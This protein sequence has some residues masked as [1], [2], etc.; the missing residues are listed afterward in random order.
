MHKF[1]SFSQLECSKFLLIKIGLCIIL[2]LTMN[3]V[4]SL[5][6]TSVEYVTQVSMYH[7]EKASTNVIRPLYAGLDKS[8]I[9]NTRHV[10]D[11][12]KKK[13]G[14]DYYFSKYP[15]VMSQ[16]TNLFSEKGSSTQINSV[17]YVYPKAIQMNENLG[18]KLSLSYENGSK[19]DFIGQN[20]KYN[21]LPIVVGSKY[22]SLFKVG[23][24]LELS[25][26]QSIGSSSVDENN[27]ELTTIKYK[28]RGILEEGQVISDYTSNYSKEICLDDYLVLPL[29]IEQETSKTLWQPDLINYFFITRKD[30]SSNPMEIAGTINSIS[31][32]SSYLGI[33]LQNENAQLNYFLEHNKNELYTAALKCTLFLCFFILQINVIIGLMFEKQKMVYTIFFQLGC[34]KGEIRKYL[35]ALYSFFPI[36][37]GSILV[38]V[39]DMGFSQNVDPFYLLSSI[40]VCTVFFITVSYYSVQKFMKT[41]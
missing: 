36:V 19:I 7:S 29:S 2:G 25:W 31:N 28:V 30:I 27:G 5:I 26:L 34:T 23:D 37:V 15:S 4:Y 3:S 14:S 41:F 1:I 12:L 18:N 35:I 39:S 9:Q 40:V 8:E 11:T 21:E 20:R 38:I 33:F 17:S 16:N 10:V 32:R 13:L 24:T 6:Q 22:K